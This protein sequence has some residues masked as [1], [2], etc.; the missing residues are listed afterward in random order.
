MAPRE[1]NPVGVVLAEVRDMGPAT[2][3]EIAKGTGLSQSTVRRHLVHLET[4]GLVES[5][6]REYGSLR[7]RTKAHRRWREV[8]ARQRLVRL[9][10]LE[11]IT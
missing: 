1:L 10:D 3:A 4:S 9:Y 2:V 8:V 5:D 7:G 11:P 6:A